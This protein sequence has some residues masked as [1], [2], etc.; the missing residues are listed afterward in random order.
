MPLM[1]VRWAKKNTMIIGSVNMV[2]AAISRA[3]ST[4]Y[5]AKKSR[6]PTDSVNLPESHRKTSGSM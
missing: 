1:K 2:A 5:W 4:P 6:R 3:H